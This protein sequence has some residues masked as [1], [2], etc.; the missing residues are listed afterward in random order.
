M[1]HIRDRF[2]EKDKENLLTRKVSN[3]IVVCNFEY[4]IIECGVCREQ[5]EGKR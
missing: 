1:F 5:E 4:K 2:S 3:L